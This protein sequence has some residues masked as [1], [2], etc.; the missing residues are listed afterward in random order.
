MDFKSAPFAWDTEPF[1]M[2]QN[3]GA[4]YIAWKAVDIALP[5]NEN[6]INKRNFVFSMALA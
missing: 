3:A 4:V 5:Q 1:E 6:F 2:V